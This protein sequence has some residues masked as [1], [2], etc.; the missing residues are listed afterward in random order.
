[1]ELYDL[2]KLSLPGMLHDNRK[3]RA[4]IAVWVTNRPKFRRFLKNKFFPD[5]HILEPYTEWYWVK[6]TASPIKNGETVLADGGRPLFDL[7]SR[8]PRRCYEGLIL[9]WY[10]PFAIREELS[11]TDRSLPSK[12]FLSVP[13]N[14]SRKPNILDLLSPHLPP[15]PNVL[16]LFSR[17][18]SGSA[19]GRWHSLG[20]ESPKFMVPPWIDSQTEENHRK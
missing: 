18:V 1:M 16:E 2:F 14:H 13:L 5:C 15:N 7:E 12:I 9:G 11:S 19:S 8:S 10:T 20:D 3:K 17:S 4:L 6:I